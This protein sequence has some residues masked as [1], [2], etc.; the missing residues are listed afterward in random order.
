MPPPE[1]LSVKEAAINSNR[2]QRASIAIASVF[3]MSVA[4]L[5]ACS[6]RGVVAGEP[7]PRPAEANAEIAALAQ[8]RIDLAKFIYGWTVEH[9]PTT[10]KEDVDRCSLNW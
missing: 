9:E 4:A 7:A 3:V 8:K 2:K 6:S 1:S 10:P 5:G